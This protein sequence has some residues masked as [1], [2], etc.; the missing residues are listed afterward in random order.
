VE[1]KLSASAR[2]I[3]EMLRKSGASFFVDIVQHSGMLRTQTEDALAELAANG[4]VTSDSFAGLRALIAPSG[5][6]PGFARAGQRRG[7]VR[8]DID[9]AGRWSLLG[10]D[11]AVT[12]DVAQNGWLRTDP[13]T[14]A[15]VAATLLRRY[16]VVF[17]KVLERE[18]QLPP[19]RE[20]LYAYRRMEAR[21]EIRGGRFV[22]GFGGEQFALPEAVGLLRR[23]DGKS[24]EQ[25]IVISAADPLNLVGSIVPGEKI[26]V[27]I[28]NR[29][30]FS[31]GLPIVVQAGNGIEFATDLSPEDIWRARN[32]LARRHN[33][34]GYLR[35]PRQT[36]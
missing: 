5:R 26:P 14:L 31:N 17:R 33:P 18:S 7:P 28:H 13:E 10:Q 34:A 27:S 8:D 11:A 9:A 22:E 30:V 16:G 4:L 23:D 32:L 20:L 36:F 1:S 21:G 12:G 15:H 6:R 29:I 25:L 35:T 24:S 19:W 3:L 2:K